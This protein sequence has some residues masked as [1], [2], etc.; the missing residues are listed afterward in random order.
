VSFLPL[1]GR[2]VLDVTT[3]YAGPYCT[4]LLAALGAE[5]LK[6]ESPKGGDPTRTWGPPFWSGESTLF[7]AANAGKRSVA[8]SLGKPDGRE[9]LLRLAERADVFVQSLRPGLAERRGLGPDDVRARNRGVVYCTIGSYGRTGPLRDLPG[10]DP[11]MQAAAGIVSVTGEPDRPG[12]RAGVS[13]VDQ[14]TGQWAVI[15]ILAALLEGGGRTV[16]VSLFETAVSYL[17]YQLM[18]Y[19]GTGEVPAR[20]GTGF[21]LIAPYEV[22]RAADGELMIAAANNALFQALCEAL[23]LPLAEETRFATNPQR[24]ANRDELVRLL[25][26]RL[27]RETVET[28]LERLGRA[29]VP[30]APVRDVAEVAELE[31]TRALGLLQHVEHAAVPGLQLVAPPLSVDGERTA[32][33]A[34]PPALGADTREALAEA[35]Y[36]DAEID[37]LAAAGVVRLGTQ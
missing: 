7:L 24:V 30:A 11:M 16:D 13:L 28:W 8:I 15:G 29:G 35:G 1:E 32:H 12:V 26:E 22:F 31:Q 4:Q 34:P 36:S 9:A 14:G 25:N 10:Y 18:S 6:I 21:A 33:R 19:L 37:A 3:S 17:P 23:E 27:E 2:R 5:V 20:Y